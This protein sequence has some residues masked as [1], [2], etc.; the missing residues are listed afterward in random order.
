[1]LFKADHQELSC[2]LER[3]AAWLL[4]ISGTE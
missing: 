4:E 2:H 3:Q 1:M